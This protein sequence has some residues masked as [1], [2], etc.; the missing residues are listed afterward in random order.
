M[1]PSSQ[2][3]RI[4]QYSVESPQS[5]DKFEKFTFNVRSS[6]SDQD[7]LRQL[8]SLQEDNDGSRIEVMDA[9][10]EPE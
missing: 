8:E 5:A 10:L 4:I 3:S 6:Q 1:P 9:F 2:M 7:S